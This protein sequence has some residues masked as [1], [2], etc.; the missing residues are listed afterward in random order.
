MKSIATNTSETELFDFLT[1]L[2]QDPFA[3][4]AYARDPGAVLARAGLSED[5]VARAGRRSKDEIAGGAWSL[6]Q[7][8]SDPGPDPFPEGTPEEVTR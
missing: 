1:G 3:Q 2:A 7:T 6:C 5:D 8:C 4:E